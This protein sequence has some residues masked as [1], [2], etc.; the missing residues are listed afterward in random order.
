MSE[1]RAETLLRKLLTGGG[2]V[3]TITDWDGERPRLIVDVTVDLTD[4]EV[5]LVR[6]LS[7]EE[8]QQ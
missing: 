5:E 3:R 4:E 7:A 1:N 2:Y 6:H 8:G